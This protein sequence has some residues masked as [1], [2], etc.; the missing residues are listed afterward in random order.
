MKEL[1]CF[2]AVV[3]SSIDKGQPSSYNEVNC[4]SNSE[5]LPY[6]W[7]L[8]VKKKFN[9]PAKGTCYGYVQ[10]YTMYIMQLLVEYTFLCPQFAGKHCKMTFTSL[11]R[12]H[13]SENDKYHK[14]KSYNLCKISL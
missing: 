10:T 9:K 6:T 12:D 5:L 4:A 8:I 3:H 14:G 1:C 11:S 13:M 2:S 7:T